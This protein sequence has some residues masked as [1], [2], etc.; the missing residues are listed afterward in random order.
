[1]K[2][3][4]LQ[5]VVKNWVIDRCGK[6]SF[7]APQERITR[8][9]E[10]AFE[11]AQ[12]LGLD[13]KAIKALLKHVYS[14]PEGA[15]NQELAGVGVTLLALAESLGFNLLTVIET[16]VDRLPNISKSRISRKI[17]MNSNKGIGL[18]LTDDQV[19]YHMAQCLLEGTENVVKI[20]NVTI[21]RKGYEEYSR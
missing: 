11:L 16:E 9:L 18:Q 15:V 10:E 3:S 2:L 14:R 6:D 1:M 20:G 21:T 12:V 17:L 5:L 4:T 13:K 7:E 19:K 8:V